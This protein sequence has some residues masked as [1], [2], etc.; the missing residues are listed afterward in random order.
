MS[1]RLVHGHDV[2]VYA[3]RF[4]GESAE[5][6]IAGLSYHRVSRYLDYPLKPL[7]LLDRLRIANPRRP[8][9]ASRLYFLGY[10]LQVARDIRRRQCDIIH[11]HNFSQYVPIVRFFNPRARIVLHMHCDWLTMLDEKLVRP[12]I[13][14]ADMVLGVSDFVT[15]RL[16]A[17]FPEFADRFH[18]LYNGVDSHEFRPP[19]EGVIQT[20][21]GKPRVICVGR[22]SPEKGVHT[23]IDAFERVLE[24]FPAATLDIIGPG[25][26][27][28]REFLDPSRQ[29]RLLD[30]M[31]PF[32][33]SR[34]SYVPYLQSRLS[35]AAQK[36][37]R[38][39]GCVPH[40]KLL[41]YYQAADVFVIPSVIHE[42]FGIP[43]AEAMACGLPVVATRG[44]GFPEI[45]V[46]HETGEMVGRGEA[47]ELADALVKLLGDPQ[48]R[49]SQGEAGRKRL[50][51]RFSWDVVMPKLEELYEQYRAADP[52][53]ASR[54]ANSSRAT[55][56]ALAGSRWVESDA[57]QELSHR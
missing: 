19:D 14:Q 1:R 35:P 53:G 23:L 27:G 15:D 57:P 8:H 37:V 28:S 43:L 10:I 33:K 36:A 17:K 55:A 18:T 34:E 44:G 22:V 30:E 3:P 25:R 26:T 13:A 41:S 2:T 5:E 21:H 38:F 46:N 24:K 52:A 40:E 9:V 47:G 11:L 56:D 42:P 39:V 6:S 32:F 20:D 54:S 45:L 31:D 51:E 48:L 7:R 4:D 29:E 49:R 16:K 50:L 12:R